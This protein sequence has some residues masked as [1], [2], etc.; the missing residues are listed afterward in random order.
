MSDWVPIRYLGFWDV[1]RNFLV[2]YAGEL[3][4]FDC[5]FSEAL[6]D[7]PDTYAVYVLPEMSRD[8]IDQDWAGLPDKALR[9]VGDVPIAA[10]T[11]DPTM[12]TAIRAEV[13]DLL[14][15]AN[16]TPAHADAP[17]ARAS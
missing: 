15:H 13:L 3:L 4:L 17:P 14:P 11:F 7:Y 2:R 5:P 6:D 1:P 8:E 16:G 9:K 12:R 10:V